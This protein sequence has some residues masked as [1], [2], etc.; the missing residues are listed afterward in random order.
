[1]NF[2]DPFTMLFEAPFRITRAL[3]EQIGMLGFRAL[4]SS[5]NQ[6]LVKLFMTTP[7]IW[8]NGY[9]A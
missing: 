7:A 3:W 8:C 6:D 5:R 2:T 1:M 4:A 9:F